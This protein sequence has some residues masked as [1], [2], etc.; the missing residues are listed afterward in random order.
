[1]SKSDLEPD[2]TDLEYE[3]FL[4]TVITIVMVKKDYYWYNDRLV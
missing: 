3:Y 2:I 1:M 4:S